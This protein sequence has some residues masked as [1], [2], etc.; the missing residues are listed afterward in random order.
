MSQFRIDH[1]DFEFIVNRRS[2]LQ[3]LFIFFFLVLFVNTHIFELLRVAI[4]LF[5]DNNIFFMIDSFSSPIFQDQV[6]FFFV[7]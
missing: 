1:P 3:S 5:L 4:P 6:V 2:H 7:L